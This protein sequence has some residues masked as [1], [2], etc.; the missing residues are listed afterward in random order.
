MLQVDMRINAKNKVRAIHFKSSDLLN[1]H[2]HIQTINKLIINTGIVRI[3]QPNK[4]PDI[5]KVIFVL[6]S[7]VRRKSI[8]RKINE[9][10]V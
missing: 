1:R 6:F 5:I 3:K 4:R 2:N 7:F 8:K 9:P 10:I